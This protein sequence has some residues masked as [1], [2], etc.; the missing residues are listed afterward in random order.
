MIHFFVF[1]QK[2]L[3]LQN[4]AFLHVLGA[5]DFESYDL[6]SAELWSTYPLRSTERSVLW[7]V[8]IYLVQLY[9]LPLFLLF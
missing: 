1:L 3:F 2:R 8:M 4:E 6:P 7:F 5:A 9:D